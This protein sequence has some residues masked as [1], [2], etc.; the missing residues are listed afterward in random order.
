MHIKVGGGSVNFPRDAKTQSHALTPAAADTV[1]GV[2]SRLKGT[3]RR[4]R[5]GHT[6]TEWTVLTTMR[7][8]ASRPDRPV[9][10]CTC[11]AVSSRTWRGKGGH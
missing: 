2:T 4:N 6:D 1:R 8:G 11:R 9:K 3:T 10:S 7:T 5:M